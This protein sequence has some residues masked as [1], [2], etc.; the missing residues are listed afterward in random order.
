[1]CVGAYLREPL[2]TLEATSPLSQA[3]SLLHGGARWALT[4]CRVSGFAWETVTRWT[5]GGH[6][7]AAVRI[8]I[9]I[10][11]IRS[12]REQIQHKWQQCSSETALSVIWITSQKLKLFFASPPVKIFFKT[13]SQ[14]LICQV[15]LHYALLT[16]CRKN[17]KGT[18][19]GFTIKRNIT[20]RDVSPEWTKT[21]F[22]Y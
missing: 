12:S 11:L 21:L 17:L 22:A 10:S 20:K 2:Y 5:D 16:D 7:A 13:N 6:S 4:F 9:V 15:G 3:I 8:S 19:V 14:Q 18:R 1:M